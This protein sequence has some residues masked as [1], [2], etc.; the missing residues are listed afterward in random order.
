MRGFFTCAIAEKSRFLSRG[1]MQK[2]KINKIAYF[3]IKFKSVKNILKAIPEA[4]Y[5]C[6]RSMQ[7]K[8]L[9]KKTATI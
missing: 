7:R 3:G 5:S 1:K 8:W 4:Q 2:R 9:K 6:C